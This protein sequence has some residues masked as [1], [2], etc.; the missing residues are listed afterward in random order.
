MT[1]LTVLYKADS[2]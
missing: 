1:T 2:S